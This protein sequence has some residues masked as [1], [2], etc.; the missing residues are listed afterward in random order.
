MKM[1][2]DGPS[3]VY[4]QAVTKTLGVLA[5][6]D[7]LDKDLIVTPGLSGYFVP[8][9]VTLG[10]VGWTTTLTIPRKDGTPT[11]RLVDAA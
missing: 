6:D 4:T 9:V 11:R 2:K 8:V 7:C 3:N 5:R 1:W 10:L